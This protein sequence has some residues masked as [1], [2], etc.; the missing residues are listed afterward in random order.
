MTCM[1][2]NEGLSWLLIGN[3]KEDEERIYMLECVQVEQVALVKAGSFDRMCDGERGSNSSLRCLECRTKLGRSGRWDWASKQELVING[4]VSKKL[5]VLPLMGEW[6]RFKVEWLNERDRLSLY[7][8]IPLSDY[9]LVVYLR[10]Y[11]THL[12]K[13]LWTK[14]LSS[15]LVVLLKLIHF[16]RQKCLLS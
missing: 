8:I 12:T 15:V 9:P 1:L 4:Q 13:F 6:W 16:T 14:F 7:L 5:A 2:N 3:V 10:I 11:L